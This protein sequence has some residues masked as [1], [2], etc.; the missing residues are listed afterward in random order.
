[1]GTCWYVM[2]VDWC[3]V[4]LLKKMIIGVLGRKGGGSHGMGFRKA[5]I[6]TIELG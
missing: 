2:Q 3:E 1:M 6:Q 5:T 4:K